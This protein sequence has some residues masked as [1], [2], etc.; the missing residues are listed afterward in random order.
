MRIAFASH[1]FAVAALGTALLSGT[2]LVAVLSWTN[3]WVD[4]DEALN[5]TLGS[6]GSP[7]PFVTV[8]LSLVCSVFCLALFALSWNAVK[9]VRM[10]RRPQACDE[11]LGSRGAV[12]GRWCM[13]RGTTFVVVVFFWSTIVVCLFADVLGLSAF[14]AIY[15]MLR[16]EFDMFVFYTLPL[17]HPFLLAAMILMLPLLLRALLYVWR[18]VDSSVERATVIALYAACFVGMMLFL[19]S[20]PLLVYSRSPNIVPDSAV[21]PPKPRFWAHRL[22]ASWGPE[23]TMCALNRTLNWYRS[24][25]D[26]Q[27]SQLVGVEFDVRYTRDN[28]PV[29]MHDSTLLKTTNV[30]DVFPANAT[31]GINSFTWSQ[32]SKLNAGSWFAKRDAYHMV[33]SRW[34]SQDEAQSYD[35]G[36]GVPTFAQ[37]LKAVAAVPDL[38]IM[39]NVRGG[40]PRRYAEQLLSAVS[41]AGLNNRTVWLTGLDSHLAT[42]QYNISSLAPGVR[43]AIED[44]TL[45]DTEMLREAQEHGFQFVNSPLVLPKSDFLHSVPRSMTRI[46]YQLNA[47][48]LFSQLWLEGKVDL[49]ATNS[50]QQLVDWE[51]P[52]SWTVFASTYVI[53]AACI[54]VVALLMCALIIWHFVQT[55]IRQPAKLAAELHVSNGVHLRPTKGGDSRVQLVAGRTETMSNCGNEEE[56]EEDG[57]VAT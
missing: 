9:A 16:S 53:T 33:G 18:T 5:E 39:W 4:I 54:D 13:G 30:R 25:S 23:N 1:V 55:R 26:A 10:M 38:L 7:V 12:C 20:V 24:A 21:L 28:V 36:C 27:R 31:R 50:F 51:K 32:V 17:A 3:E 22:G 57:C 15:G 2:F 19:L 37:V 49:V 8:F 29:L 6:A 45:S 35:N 40:R 52:D 43:L 42:L 11:P 41:A 56:E 44:D 46:G 34:L 14:Y 47:P 48:W